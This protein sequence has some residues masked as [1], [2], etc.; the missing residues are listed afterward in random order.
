MTAAGCAAMMLRAAAIAPSA[1]QPSSTAVTRTLSP[2]RPPVELIRATA[3]AH[4]ALL[5]LEELEQEKL[6]AFRAKYEA[7][8]SSARADLRRGGLDTDTPQC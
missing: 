7:L 3:G 2:R 8:A 4:N 5:D 6:D 1:V